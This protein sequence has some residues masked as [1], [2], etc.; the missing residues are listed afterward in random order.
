MKRLNVMFESF[1]PIPQLLNQLNFKRL[2]DDEQK[3]V[4]FDLITFILRYY[5]SVDYKDFG[6][7]EFDIE[8]IKKE[9]VK[10]IWTS[11]DYVL[12]KLETMREDI[13]NKNKLTAKALGEIF[14][15]L[16]DFKK[17]Y[18]GIG[19]QLNRSSEPGGKLQKELGDIK[20]QI[21]MMRDTMG[22]SSDMFKDSLNHLQKVSSP[23]PNRMFGDGITSEIMNMKKKM[24]TLVLGVEA[25]ENTL[26][27]I[28]NEGKNRYN[29]I[30]DSV[31]AEID[32]LKLFKD[33]VEIEVQILKKQYNQNLN[34]NE[35]LNLTLKDKGKKDKD[36]FKLQ[37]EFLE[38]KKKVDKLEEENA[39]L[40]KLTEKKIDLMASKIQDLEDNTIT[41][42]QM[43]QDL[44]EVLKN[45]KGHENN[46]FSEMSLEQV[47]EFCHNQKKINT[48]LNTQVELLQKKLDAVGGDNYNSR[49]LVSYSNPKSD[50]TQQNFGKNNPKQNTAD[51]KDF[52]D[53]WRL[54]QG[55]LV[56]ISEIQKMIQLDVDALKMLNKSLQ[57]NN[58][59]L[60][61]MNN[62]DSSKIPQNVIKEIQQI[63]VQI[64]WFKERET[65]NGKKVF[66]LEGEIKNIKLDYQ[67]LKTKLKRD[68]LA[69]DRLA[70]LEGTVANSHKE[71]AKKTREIEAEIRRIKT[72]GNQLV[73]RRDDLHESVL[74]TAAPP[75]N[76]KAIIR[77][78]TE[79]ITEFIKEYV[80][81]IAMNC[82]SVIRDEDL[83]A[84]QKM[85]AVDWMVRNLEF[86]SPKLVDKFLNFCHEIHDAHVNAYS[87]NNFYNSSHKSSVL[88]SIRKLI[89][90]TQ[91]EDTSDGVKNQLTQ[92][93]QFLEITLMSENNLKKAV[94][95]NIPQIVLSILLN[96]D[97]SENSRLQAQI[98][99]GRM[100][101]YKE[102]GR[103]IP[104][105]I[106]TPFFA[107]WIST[108]LENLPS[109]VSLYTSAFKI[110][111][112]AFE[113]ISVTELIFKN[114]HNLA[115]NLIRVMRK[116]KEFTNVL[117]LNLQVIN[118]FLKLKLLFF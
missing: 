1:R 51:F 103:L 43:N 83:N 17:D 61:N 59:F 24:T 76:L 53:K 22:Q 97:S 107:H 15:Y 49:E 79:H 63:K 8:Q 3:A 114:S 2:I 68:H 86:T 37:S 94:E 42:G 52:E 98:C 33:R 91:I 18:D 19:P 93:M 4:V 55:D 58:Q 113:S 106:D 39:K 34:G 92:Y 75:T 48:S 105:L 109:D 89:L 41:G 40:S 31:Q 71:L 14:S 112:K 115:N 90:E 73:T 21:Q 10:R 80:N 6:L 67:D 78:E 25:L 44:K 60:E 84:T 108:C 65:A 29:H 26:S 100:I 70:A 77:K 99:F 30:E 47:S 13:K 23:G 62:I 102:G 96:T 56:K 69:E 111:T 118:F 95:L 54:M 45:G 116:T 88:K 28:K 27:K 12:S 104:D 66:T 11:V 38:M 74:G 72:P 7:D 36:N 5:S 110:L 57:G 85:D 82:V 9:E 32:T 87:G 64:D 20:N 35:I 81:E 16:A 50:K 46:I 101:A 117:F